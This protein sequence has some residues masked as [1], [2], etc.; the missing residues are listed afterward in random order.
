MP[1]EVSRLTEADIQG[2][3]TCIQLA[4]AED[5]YNLWVYNDRSKVGSSPTIQHL[6]LPFYSAVIFRLNSADSFFASSTAYSDQ[7]ESD[8]P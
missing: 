6:L 5:P 3:I 7:W 1:I 4:F 2:A 8:V